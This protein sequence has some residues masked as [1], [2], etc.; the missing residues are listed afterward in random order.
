MTKPSAAESRKRLPLPDCLRGLTLISMILYH[1]MWNLVWLYGVEL[2]WF[3]GTPGYLWQQNICWTFILL[4]GFCW[5]LGRHHLRRGLLVFGGGVL[6]SVVTALVLPQERILWG[7]LTCT[8]SCMLLMIPLDRICKKIPPLW[9]AAGAFGL[10]FLLRNCNDGLLGFEGLVLG[11][12][13]QVLYRNLFTAYLGFPAPDFRSADYFSLI[14]WFFL[15]VCGY[16]LFRLAE[17]RNLTERFF[18]RGQLPGVNW[19]GRH[20]LLV[21]LLHQ[22]VLY[23]ICQLIFS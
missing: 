4:S 17:S 21:Y 22:P 10:F 3:T 5:N 2:P 14:P 23:G 11:R 19:L 8:G 1:G 13:P 12:L 9:G 15:F 7:I 18:S 20:S 6:V 16:F